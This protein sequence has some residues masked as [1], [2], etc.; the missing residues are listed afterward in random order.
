[1]T[2]RYFLALVIALVSL[3]THAQDDLGRWT[4]HPVFASENITNCIDTGDKVYYL[5]SGTLFCYDK[6]TQENEH[7]SRTNYL[8]DT[9]V[10]NIYYNATKHYMMVAYTNSN[11]D[12]IDVGGNRLWLRYPQRQQA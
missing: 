1:M 2:S 6:E 10:S 8:N 11:I 4:L 9:G 3:M 7:L 12:V 5:V